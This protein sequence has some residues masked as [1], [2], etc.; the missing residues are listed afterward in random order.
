MFERD[1]VHVLD[2]EGILAPAVRDQ[3]RVA[4]VVAESG[5]REAENLARGPGEDLVDDHADQVDDGMT[6]SRDVD[7]RSNRGLRRGDREALDR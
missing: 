7:E 4:N 1:L 5:V 6:V 2:A 3:N